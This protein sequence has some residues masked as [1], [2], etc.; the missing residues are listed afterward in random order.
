MKE[1]LF[2]VFGIALALSAVIFSI[3]GLK[4]KNFPGRALPLVI[5]WF[6][7]L[8]VAA[9]TYA[10]L[11]SKLEQEHREAELEHAGLVFEEEDA[12]GPAESET[13]AGGEEGSESG[14]EAPA[15]E[16]AGAGDTLQL[17]ADETALLYD[18][19]SLESAA[20]EVT[21][22]FDNPSSIP[23]DVAI[24]QDGTQIA[25]TE[26]ITESEDS[27]TTDLEPGSY[28]FYCTVPGHRE[29]GMEGT[30]EVE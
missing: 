27:L 10:V 6:V 15:G 18:T 14:G 17:A 28:V 21:I 16:S 25:A 30:L 3:L 29:A 19:D 13:P 24:E 12:E 22:E 1:T 20:G 8:T 7:A 23:H 9:A 4:I 11:F 5:V 26:V 2:Y